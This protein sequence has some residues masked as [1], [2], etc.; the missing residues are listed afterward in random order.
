MSTVALWR[1][2]SARYRLKT[3]RCAQCGA[4]HFPAG[5]ICPNLLRTDAQYNTIGLFQGNLFHP[6][7]STQESEMTPCTS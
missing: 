4:L 2:N 7:G 1:S 5:V 3:V 6:T